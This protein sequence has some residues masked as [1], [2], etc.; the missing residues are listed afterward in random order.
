[1]QQTKGKNIQM[2]ITLE[3][4]GRGRGYDMHRYHVTTGT[5]TCAYIIPVLAPN[6]GG[7]RP[8]PDPR[9]RPGEARGGGG[10]QAQATRGGAEGR[11]E[12]EKAT[13]LRRPGPGERTNLTDLSGS[14]CKHLRPMC[15]N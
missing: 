15:P 7:G 3:P 11:R 8:G 2:G 13:S 12:G 4:G 6:T 14:M 10:R 1:M 9:T 5:N